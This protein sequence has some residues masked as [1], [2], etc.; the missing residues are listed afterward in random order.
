MKKIGL[1]ALVVM[2]SACS[3][4]VQTDT[5][6]LSSQPA[7]PENIEIDVMFKV[8]QKAP[9]ANAVSYIA[10]TAQEIK[11]T[12]YQQVTIVGYTDKTG[13]IEKN[14]V[15]SH[16][17]ANIVKQTFA[18]NGVPNEKMVAYGLGA[19]NEKE[20]CGYQY[21]K[22]RVELKQCHDKNRRVEVTVHY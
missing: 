12:A 15:L 2:L 17:R 16:Q 14:L 9:S 20:Q 5:A 21:Q 3:A 8:N 22:T 4:N 11:E 18:Q 7:K 6:E 19:V 10:K 1:F 13:S